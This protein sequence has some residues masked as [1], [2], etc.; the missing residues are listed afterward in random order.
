M[1]G[2]LNVV[3]ADM[4]KFLIEGMPDLAISSLDIDGRV[5]LWNAGAEKLTGFTA[6]QME[7]KNYTNLYLPEERN[8]NILAQELKQAKN[9]RFE[10][11]AYIKRADGTKVWVDMVLAP[12]K[13]EGGE[14]RGLGLI[15]RDVTSRKETDDM[16]LRQSADLIELSTPVITL[17]DGIIA[18]PIIGT[19]DS[20]RSQVMMEKLLT[21]LVRTGAGVAILDITGV[22]T[23]DTLVA[24][25]LMKTIQ[26]ARMMGAD[27]IISGIRPE[28][29]QTIVHLGI[30]LSQVK[31]KATMARALQEA[32][33][34]NNLAIVR[35]T[36]QPP[37]R[38]L[39]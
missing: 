10:K 5:E 6:K 30:D 13:D 3:Q 39:K 38:N 15:I 20:A 16:L 26:A 33:E 35:R 37:G 9:A 7:G 1:S 8:D 29:A 12:S 24:Q 25:H 14:L 23:I 4:Y 19:L 21:E 17:W 32:L 11:A 36:A 2:Q 28:I 18:L 34:M 22:P 27:C 31:T